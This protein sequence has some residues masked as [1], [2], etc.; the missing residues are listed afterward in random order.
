MDK[1][2]RKMIFVGVC[3]YSLI[4]GIILGS[5]LTVYPVQAQNGFDLGRYF[6]A[7]DRKLKD[8]QDDIDDIKEDAKEIR[9]AQK[10]CR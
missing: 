3:G 4:A 5:V 8:M 6:Q 9:A 10:S 1:I 7:L 2:D